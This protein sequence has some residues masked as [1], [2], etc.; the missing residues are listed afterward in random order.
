MLIGLIYVYGDQ[1]GAG[2]IRR[3]GA[4][5]GLVEPLRIAQRAITAQAIK[6]SEQMRADR[7]WRNAD[8]QQP[9]GDQAD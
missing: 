2:R 9:T 1:D 6:A 3:A 5:I 8:E 4:Q 7:R